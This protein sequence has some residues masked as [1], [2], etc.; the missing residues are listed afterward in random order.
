MSH[1]GL[2]GFDQWQ[3]TERSAPSCTT[4]CG[5]F[6]SAE[7]VNSSVVSLKPP[8]DRPIDGISILPFLQGKVEHRNQSIYWAYQIPGNFNTGKYHVSTSG[9]QYK[10]IATYSNG[11][12]THYELYDLLN[13]LGENKDLSKEYP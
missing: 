6:P 11:Q 2:H 4:N 10:L 5:Y 3:A 8:D 1:S 13:D 12:V 9:D 7:C